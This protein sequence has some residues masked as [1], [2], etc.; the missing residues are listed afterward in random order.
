[1]LKGG[2]I[3]SGQLQ[4]SLGH[5]FLITSLLDWTGSG[6]QMYSAY[7]TGHHIKHNPI[8]WQTVPNI[9]LVSFK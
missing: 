4:E 2:N 6:P 5:Y 9:K 1:M 8:M 3:K 7:K